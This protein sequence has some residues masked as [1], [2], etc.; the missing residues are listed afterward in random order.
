MAN[1]FGLGKKGRQLVFRNSLQN[2]A[3]IVLCLYLVV[4]RQNILKRGYILKRG[5][6]QNKNREQEEYDTLVEHEGSQY[7]GK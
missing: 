4:W 3:L 7:G 2:S 1:L 5:N 6:H